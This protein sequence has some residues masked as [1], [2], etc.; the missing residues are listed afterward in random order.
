MA[1]ALEEQ[2]TLAEKQQA[3]AV[4]RAMAIAT[5]VMSAPQ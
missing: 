5:E 3:L 2:R 1:A 4:E